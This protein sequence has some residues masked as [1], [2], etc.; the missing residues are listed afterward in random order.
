MCEALIPGTTLPELRR[1]ATEAG[2]GRLLPAADGPNPAGSYDD[3]E[4][5]WFFSIPV[6]AEYGDERCGIY[7][8]G[9]VVLK[10]AMEWL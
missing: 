3:V 7:N 10:A 5:N 8:D 9:N 1:I 4:K 2:V 6:V